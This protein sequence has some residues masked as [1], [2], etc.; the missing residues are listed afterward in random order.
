M[1][2]V[3]AARV[4]GRS[5]SRQTCASALSPGAGPAA[6]M[7]RRVSASMTTCTFAENR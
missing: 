4:V 3:P 5:D 2:V 7:T 6:A 1:T